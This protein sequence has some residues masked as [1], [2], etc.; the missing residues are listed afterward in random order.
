MRSVAPSIDHYC[1][2]PKRRQKGH[3]HKAT[4]RDLHTDRFQLLSTARESSSEL[5][6]VFV[7]LCRFEEST[8]LSG[9]PPSPLTHRGQASLLAADSR[10][11]RMKDSPWSGF[12]G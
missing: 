7:E 2:C 6:A 9:A 8:R 1:A 12:I 5:T 10:R 4:C 3:L 11:K